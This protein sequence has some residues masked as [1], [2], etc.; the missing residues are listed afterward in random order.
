MA[1][2]AL[3]TFRRQAINAAKDFH[4]GK[5]VIKQLKEAKSDAE[6]DRI[7]KTARHEKFG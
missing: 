1:Y 5:D 4:Y 3:E 2:D 6:I 7:M